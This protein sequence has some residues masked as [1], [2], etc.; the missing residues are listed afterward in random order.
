MEQHISPFDTLGLEYGIYS[1]DQIQSAFRVVSSITHGDSRSES[2][3][4]KPKWL[5][6]EQ[7]TSAKNLLLDLSQMGSQFTE[8]AKKFSIFP[9]TVFV[10]RKDR[11]NEITFISP[12]K[13][14]IH[15][16]LALCDECQAIVHK[17]D[18]RRHRQTHNNYCCTHC[19]AEFSRQEYLSHL[20]VNDLDECQICCKAVTKGAYTRHLERTHGWAKCPFC[21]TLYPSL[22]RM[23]EHL[24]VTHL[25]R[26]CSSCPENNIHELSVHVSV[27][28]QCVTCLCGAEICNESLLGHLERQHWFS[29][30]SSGEVCIMSGYDDHD[31]ILAHINKSHPPDQCPVCECFVFGTGTFWDHLSQRHCFRLCEKCNISDYYQAATGVQSN[32]RQ[33]HLDEN[34]TWKECR[35]C[36]AGIQVSQMPEH[37]QN[38][39]G[40]MA[41]DVCAD[42]WPPNELEGHKMRQ[43]RRCE[44][45]DIY[46]L[47]ENYLQHLATHGKKPCPL[48]DEILLL[49]EFP[50]HFSIEHTETNVCPVSDCKTYHSESGLQVHVCQT[51]GWGKCRF[52]DTTTAPGQPLR[53]HE[54]KHS[55]KICQICD[56]QIPAD[57]FRQH[58]KAEHQI[59]E[60]PFCEKSGSDLL[61]HIHNHHPL[62]ET[63]AKSANQNNTALD[64]R[65]GACEADAGL[66]IPNPAS[67][68]AQDKP[69]GIYNLLN[70]VRESSKQSLSAPSHPAITSSATNIIGSIGDILETQSRQGVRNA[71]ATTPIRDQVNVSSE[72]EDMN[73]SSRQVGLPEGA[74]SNRR[75]ERLHTSPGCVTKRNFAESHATPASKRRKKV[76]IKQLATHIGSEE[77]KLGFRA[78][79][80]SCLTNT[81][82]A[83]PAFPATPDPAPDPLQLASKLSEKAASHEKAIG[84]HRLYQYI[85]LLEL[86]K[87]L[88]D[89]KHGR[90]RVSSD[91]YDGILRLQNKE[92][93]KRNKD[94]LADQI[95]LG[96]K[97]WKICAMDIGEKYLGALPFIVVAV[98]TEDILKV[99]DD[100]LPSLNVLLSRYIH[101]WTNGKMLVDYIRRGCCPEGR[102]AIEDIL[103]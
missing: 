50:L 77:T 72:E 57:D 52:C 96:R 18:L 56:E 30:C 41:C 73:V 8:N 24:G 62:A 68:P 47:D 93:N 42:A 66:V 61:H 15:E 95:R 71:R 74:H 65:K 12:S 94:K 26:R 33:L 6:F 79:I 80:Q 32:Q 58:Q 55:P 64:L 16:S 85:S 82:T 14:Q 28:H 10:E 11:T 19:E 101:L 23:Q 5:T 89:S 36:R 2:T 92:N 4:N 45:C 75:S 39:H 35:N 48:C 20:T 86:A 31:S 100:M 97:I 69:W 34:H 44:V 91:E 51:H 43:H 53:D 84:M 40:Y 1:K 7:V 25:M 60:C 78:L 98:K 81:E 76:D 67:Q 90:I 27:G 102:K 17:K 38:S 22:D 103:L 63:S 99:T 29:A 9:R 21:S 37:L 70:N 88:H 49:D 54:L 46:V 13:L 83:T 59:Q 87:V 3:S